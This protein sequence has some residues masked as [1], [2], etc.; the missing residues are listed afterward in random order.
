MVS[1]PSPGSTGLPVCRPAASPRSGFSLLELLITVA[2]ML[3]M[4][5]VFY[6]HGSRSNQQRQLKACQKNLQNI[7]LALEIYANEHQGRFPAL[8]GA[9]TSE[10]VL[11]VLVPKYTS[12]ADSFICPGSKDGKLASGE[13]L[14]GRRISYAYFMG[15]QLAETT[16]LLASDRWADTKPKPRG[17]QVFSVNGR[18]PGSNHHQYGGNFLFVDGHQ[19]TQPVSASEDLAWPPEVVLLNPRD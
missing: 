1:T 2:L 11:A 6:G 18:A 14:A 4:W 12:A 3:V 15:R 17:A 19:E 13:P 8:A 16:N 5:V 10:E 7:Y 9:R